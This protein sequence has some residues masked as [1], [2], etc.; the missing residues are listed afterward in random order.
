MPDNNIPISHL[1]CILPNRIRGNKGLIARTHW[2]TVV[3]VMLGLLGSLVLFASNYHGES[4]RFEQE[5]QSLALDRVEALEKALKSELSAI[6]TVSDY[7]AT[8]TPWSA[9]TFHRIARPVVG[10]KSGLRTLE[11]VPLVPASERSAFEAQQKASGSADF[12]ISQKA[13]SGED[14]QAS[15]RENY[16]PI[17]YMAPSARGKRRMG[18][19]HGSESTSRAAMEAA[20]ASGHPTIIQA[21]QTLNDRDVACTILVFAPVYRKAV[22][23]E[24]PPPSAQRVPAGFCVGEFDAAAEFESA[25]QELRPAGIDI[26]FSHSSAADE[27]LWKHRSQNAVKIGLWKQRA[28]AATSSGTL[29]VASTIRFAG[30]EWM[31]RLSS[32]PEFQAMRR[33][34]WPWATLAC[35]LLVTG[36]SAARSQN[37]QALEDSEARF[38]QMAEAIDCA[39]WTTGDDLR[40]TTYISP[41]YGRIWGHSAVN[42]DASMMSLLEGIH[43]EDRERTLAATMP[44][45]D[46]AEHSFT[47]EYRIIRADGATRFVRNRSFPVRDQHGRVVQMVGYA[48]DVTGQK[49]IEQALGESEVRFQAF[50][51]NSPSLMFFKDIAGRYISVNKEFEKVLG[52]HRGQAFGRTDSELFGSKQ[53]ALIAANDRQVIEKKEA[54]VFEET[55]RHKD[56]EHIGIVSKFPVQDTEGNIYAIGG[57]VTDITEQRTADIAIRRSLKEK[58]VLLKEIHHRVKNN[59]QVISSL[60]AM[61]SDTVQELHFHDLLV[62]SQNRVHAMAMIHERLYQS[63]SLSTVDFGEYLTSLSSYLCSNYGALNANVELVFDV[64][65]GI[66]LNI[67]TA[68]P[69]GLIV[70]ELVSN[71]FKH[72]FA[73]KPAGTLKVALKGMDSGH[74]LLLIA[75]DGPGIPPGLAL[76]NSPTLGTSLIDTLIRQLKAELTMG[77]PPGASFHIRFSE[78]TYTSRT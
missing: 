65:D 44:T 18:F 43:P 17:M 14:V 9:Q 73:G 56:G 3:V 48:E 66:L 35:G 34:Y 67:D 24:E 71:A 16:F 2:K 8:S 13:D 19:D 38:R 41:G 11:W 15:S 27:P 55:S 29:K 4:E 58:E 70:N 32:S 60:L 78:L 61:Q 7:W 75:D 53:G 51:Q 59:L 23:G 36:L 37:Q 72:A 63:N 10:R 74:Y 31:V 64:Q 57:V 49:Q 5:F 77:P 69:L 21:I 39:F 52:L 6:E 45:G 22:A 40:T 20:F 46:D 68:L 50:F 28:V 47:I 30:Q 33:T 42:P 26:A 54:M 62:E 1:T 12:V 76:K 25:I